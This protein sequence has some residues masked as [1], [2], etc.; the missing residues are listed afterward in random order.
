MQKLGVWVLGIFCGAGLVGGCGQRGPARPSETAG[1]S[2]Y[3]QRIPR[4]EA[5][6]RKL[7]KASPGETVELAKRFPPEGDTSSSQAPQWWGSPSLNT[8]GLSKPP[9]S[10]IKDLKVNSQEPPSSSSLG[11]LKVSEE[12]VGAGFRA[13]PLREGALEGESLRPDLPPQGPPSWQEETPSKVLREAERPQAKEIPIGN[14]SPGPRSGPR[15]SAGSGKRS[16]F[17]PYKEHGHFFVGWPKPKLALVLTGCRNGYIEPCGCAGKDRMKGG[18]SRLHSMLLELREKRGWPTVALDVGGISKGTG[19]QGVLK[20]HALADA[21]RKMGYEAVALG[22]GDL[23]YDLGDLIAVASEVDGQPGLFIS[24]NVALLSWDAG[25]T[26]KPRVIQTAGMKIG[27]IAILGREFQN[28]I[29]SKE[30]LFK[31]PEKVVR[32][33]LGELQKQCDLLIL[34]AHASRQESLQLAKKVPGFDLVVT[35][36]GAPEPPAHPQPIEGQNGWLI[37]VGEKG[38]YAV[39]VGIYDDPQ[40]PRRY[41]RV[42]LDSRYPDSE[43]MRQILLAYQEQLKDLGL[44]GLGIQAV[45]HPRQELNGPFVGSQS[46]RACHEASYKLWQHSGHARAWETLQRVDP[47]R[48]HDPECISCHVVGW[49]PQKYFP[50]ESG[51]WSQKQTPHLVAV[52]CESCHGPAGNHV[53]AELGRLGSQEAIKQKYRQAVKLSLAEAEKTCLECHD[54]DNSPDFQFST[55]WPKVAHREE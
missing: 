21:M 28:Q 25:F 51:F 54:L 55:Y 12:G 43:P 49:N 20:F 19:L 15:E 18:I 53:E 6:A 3:Q 5:S 30:I 14:P 42:V 38:M 40:Q 13:N 1:K 7:A 29:Y 47:P 10:P 24:S 32:E 26:G 2:S 22:I 39:V 17:D 31:D 23:K 34:L 9:L 45:R 48:N 27:V 33:Q 37:E 52:G 35:A 41:Q 11:S 8:P 36:G 46:C 50:Y 4:P 16:P 44:K